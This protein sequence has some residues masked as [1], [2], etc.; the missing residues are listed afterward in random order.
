MASEIEPRHQMAILSQI[1]HISHKYPMKVKFFHKCPYFHTLSIFHTNIEWS[2]IFTQMAIFSHIEHISHKYPMKVKF[3]HK[4]PYF[5]Q[6]SIFHTNIQWKSNFH[7]N[8]HIFTHWACFTQLF[9]YFSL[10]SWYFEILDFLWWSLHK[11]GASLTNDILGLIIEVMKRRIS[12][13]W[14]NSSSSTAF[15]TPTIHHFSGITTLSLLFVVSVTY[16]TWA[17]CFANTKGFKL[18]PWRLRSMLM[19]LHLSF[20]TPL[21][22]SIQ[23]QW[24]RGILKLWKSSS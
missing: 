12:S 1:E 3:S 9:W 6:L 2:Q 7:T 17:M 19:N 14:S 4:W 8:N 5:Y 24:K 10:W 16:N 21:I 23:L 20:T 18:Y 13:N 15:S 22:T 11:Y